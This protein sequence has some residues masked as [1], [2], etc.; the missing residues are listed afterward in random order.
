MH[1]A[2]VVV[3][4]IA[5]LSFLTAMMTQ[6]LVQSRSKINCMQHGYFVERLPKERYDPN[7]GWIACLPLLFAPFCLFF[8][9]PF[10]VLVLK[11]IKGDKLF[12]YVI[13]AILYFPVFLL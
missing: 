3:N 10:Q 5:F 13:C 12:N 11:I 6:T 2:F 7:V 8:V 9:Y 1:A 4:L